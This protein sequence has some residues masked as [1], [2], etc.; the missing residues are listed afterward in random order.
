MIVITKNYWL[1]LNRPKS[2]QGGL[3]QC[4]LLSLERTCV[5]VNLGPKDIST[6]S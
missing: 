5:R 2:F 4:P 1:S 3:D 6:F